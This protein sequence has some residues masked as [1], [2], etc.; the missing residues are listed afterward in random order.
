MTELN[1]SDRAQVQS[2]FES[3]EHGYV[4][5]TKKVGTGLMIITKTN[6]D[7]FVHNWRDLL[8][9]HGWYVDKHNPDESGDTITVMPLTAL[10]NGELETME[11]FL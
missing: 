11:D 5:D 4:F 8:E 1:V 6:A 10:D 9:T 7:E 2:D 3:P